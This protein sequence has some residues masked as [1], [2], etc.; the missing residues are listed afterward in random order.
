[1]SSLRISTVIACSVAA[2]AALGCSGGQLPEVVD[3]RALATG[4][5]APRI[6]RIVD[7]GASAALHP[8]ARLQPAHAPDGSAVIGELLLI[9]GSGFGRQPTF[10]VGGRAAAVLARTAGGGV[11]LRVPWGIDP[12][13]VEVEVTTAAG[14]ASSAFPIKRVGLVATGSS[15][16]AFELRADGGASLGRELPLAGARKLAIS[17][18]GVAAYVAG[19]SGGGVKLYVIDLSAPELP[20]VAEHSLPGTRAVEVAVAEQ[21]PLALVVSDT[22]FSVIDAREPARPSLYAPRPIP[23]ELVKKNV[24]AAAVSRSAAALLLADLNQ[25]AVLDLGKPG[26]PGPPALVDALPG[27]RLQTAQDLRFSTDGGSLW[28]AS[29]DT[30]R[31]IA[32]GYQ[33]LRATLLAVGDPDASR[34]RPLAVQRGWDLGDK[35]APLAVALARGEPIP[36]GTAIRVDPG[37]TALY[38]A[39]VSSALLRG[40]PAPATAGAEAGSVLRTSVGKAP[41]RVLAGARPITSLDVVGKTQIVIALAAEGARR[42]LLARRAWEARATPSVTALP[43]TDLAPGLR[44]QPPWLGEVRAQ[45]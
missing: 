38:L 23:P 40:A 17:P 16:C 15:L 39:T 31:S 45:P 20:V 3:V 33:P 43:S 1:M 24:I 35:L 22:H 4:R 8:G 5:G 19:A 10:A 37:A 28:V 30:A 2:L 32:G 26:E 34:R 14:R 7:L 36:P 9:E 44:A 11:V 42:V 29:G 21:A 27:A 12:G 18:E 13:Q 25:V 6:A 41:E